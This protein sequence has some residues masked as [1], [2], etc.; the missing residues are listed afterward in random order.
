MTNDDIDKILMVFRSAGY[1]PDATIALVP[2]NTESLSVGQRICGALAF[3]KSFK[4]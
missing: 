4:V 3:L 1:E 2:D